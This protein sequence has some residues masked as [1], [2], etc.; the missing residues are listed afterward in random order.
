MHNKNTVLS[1]SQTI[2]FLCLLFLFPS[3]VLSQVGTVTLGV[4]N[5]FGAPGSIDNPVA[6]TLDNQ[7][8]RVAAL[9]FEI[10]RDDELTLS[11]CE[12]TVRTTGFTCNT[13]DLGNGCDRILLYIFGGGFIEVGTGPMLTLEYDVSPNAPDPSL[14]VCEILDLVNELIVPCVDDGA[15]GCMSGPPLENVIV[16]NGEFCF[17]CLD[18]SDCDDGEYCTGDETCVGGVCQAGSG[19]PCPPGHICNEEIDV[20]EFDTDQDGLLDRL[21][22]CP[23]HPN[24][25]LL[26]TCLYGT[27]GETCTSSAEC[28]TDGFCD[29]N[30][31]D[32]YPPG[33]NDIGDACEC[34]GDF[35]RNGEV[36]ADDVTKFLEDFGR[37]Q[38]NNPCP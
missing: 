7:D 10:C 30:Q 28:G 11:A 14:V 6:I 29:T 24:G 22:N 4:G 12:N 20:C 26:G 16:E 25:P 2:I 36:D 19:D 37:G 18:N 3:L 1:S 13:Q 33:G 27:V 31:A 35:D 15:G 5:G 8:D 38:F 32:N 9:Q 17:G 34:E 21:D 23:N